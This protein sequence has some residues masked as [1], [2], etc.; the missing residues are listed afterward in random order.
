MDE[1]E[2]RNGTA[3]TG[4]PSSGLGEQLAGRRTTCAPEKGG[5]EPRSLA[6]T[7][8]AVPFCAPFSH[9]GGSLPAELDDTGAETGELAWLHMHRA[10]GSGSMEKFRRVTA[11]H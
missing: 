9:E 4:G 1:C 5:R 7:R 6:R 8:S 10:L 11:K 3:V 2:L